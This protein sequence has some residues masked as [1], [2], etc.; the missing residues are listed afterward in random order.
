MDTF[1]HLWSMPCGVWI[2]SETPIAARQIYGKGGSSEPP[3]LF[4]ITY[5][6]PA[7]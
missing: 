3:F 6:E 4:L 2:L 7:A 5:D 1:R